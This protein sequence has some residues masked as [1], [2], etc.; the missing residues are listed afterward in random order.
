MT[1]REEL[2]NVAD[3]RT[4]DVATNPSRATVFLQGTPGTTRTVTSL[5]APRVAGDGFVVTTSRPGYG[6]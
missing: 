6:R 3:G 4:L 5:D 2:L 1:H